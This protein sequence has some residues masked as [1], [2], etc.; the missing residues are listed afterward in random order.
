MMIKRSCVTIGT[1]YQDYNRDSMHPEDL[2]TREYILHEQGVMARF[3]ETTVATNDLPSS[4][5]A[6]T[7]VKKDEIDAFIRQLLVVESCREG[8]LSLG[9]AAEVAGV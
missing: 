7:N 9:K 8:T 1:V 5:L 6:A 4:F 2:I 3:M